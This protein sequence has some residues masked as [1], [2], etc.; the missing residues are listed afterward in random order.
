MK[1]DEVDR[2]VAASED[3]RLK[4]NDKVSCTLVYLYVSIGVTC[5]TW[6]A[7]NLHCSPENQGIYHSCTN[8][9]SR[10]LR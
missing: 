8:D 5:V 10:A 7:I 6:P 9:H 3:N 2:K 1:H 4:E